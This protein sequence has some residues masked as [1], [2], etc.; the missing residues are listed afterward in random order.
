MSAF[1]FQWVPHKCGPM[2][3]SAETMVEVRYR[4]GSTD[5]DI[6]DAFDWDHI[7]EDADIVAYCVVKMR[8]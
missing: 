8:P 2:P 4:D 5:G 6:A 1:V 3:V 7:P